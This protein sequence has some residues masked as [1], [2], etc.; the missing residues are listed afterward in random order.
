[1]YFDKKESKTEKIDLGLSNLNNFSVLGWAGVVPG[2]GP[3]PWCEYGWHLECESTGECRHNSFS[4]KQLTG[5]LGSGP[6]NQG[7]TGFLK[8]YVKAC[9]T[10]L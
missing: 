5:C 10:G 9:H 6:Q 1:M 3:L 4:E 7:N 2:L 8:N